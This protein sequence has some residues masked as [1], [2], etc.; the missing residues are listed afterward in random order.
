MRKIALLITGLLAA[1]A[2]AVT[3][4]LASSPA[5]GSALFL[6]PPPLK[7]LCHVPIPVTGETT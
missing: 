7:C 6:K 2:V 1:L 5:R 4:A 3:P